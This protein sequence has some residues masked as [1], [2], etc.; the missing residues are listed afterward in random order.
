MLSHSEAAAAAAAAAAPPSPTP[1]HAARLHPSSCPPSPQRHSLSLYIHMEG[2]P[3]LPLLVFH[4]I[5]L[6][7]WVSSFPD[8]SHLSSWFFFFFGA[9]V[10]CFFFCCFSASSLF[11]SSPP[12]PPPSSLPPP[13]ILPPFTVNFN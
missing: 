2:A 13:A 7:P 9:C 11:N 6:P 3:S 5:L 4:V 10:Y 1:S 12:P 8:L